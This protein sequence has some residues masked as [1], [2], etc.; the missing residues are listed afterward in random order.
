M[1]PCCP[2]I[3]QLRPQNSARHCLR[4]L[5]HD[6]FSVSYKQCTTPTAS[7]QSFTARPFPA[8]CLSYPPP[9]IEKTNSPSTRASKK[10]LGTTMATVYLG[11]TPCVEIFFS[12]RHL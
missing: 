1:A 3:S 5:H 8:H 12:A 4:T 2:Y 10:T 11:T 6:V 9:R 7:V